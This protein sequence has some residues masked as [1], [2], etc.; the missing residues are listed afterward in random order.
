M[1][2]SN[3]LLFYF[4]LWMSLLSCENR[5]TSEPKDFVVE[6]P[7]RKY[8]TQEYSKRD[9]TDA[10]DAADEAFDEARKAYFEYDLDD[11]EYYIK[12]AMNSF[13]DAMNYASDCDCDDAYY[14]ADSGYYY[15]RQ[16]YLSDD[17]EDINYYARKAMNEAEEAFKPGKGETHRERI[18]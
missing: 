9:C 3:G 18:T 13:E 5:K 6:A 8:Y 11:A 14:A 17:L 12:K 2:F 15:A 1:K 10:Y 7:E 16:G 4:L